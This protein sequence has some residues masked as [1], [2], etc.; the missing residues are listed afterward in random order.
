MTRPWVSPPGACYV[1]PHASGRMRGDTWVYTCPFACSLGIP[2]DS[3]T[4]TCLSACL[5]FMHAGHWVSMH[6]C[7]LRDMMTCH[8][9]GV[10]M[11]G[12]ASCTSTPP[13]YIDT[14]HVKWLIPRPYPLDQATSS[15][16]IRFRDSVHLVNFSPD[17]SRI[18]SAPF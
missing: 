11:H 14:Q 13:Y 7:M 2:E 8:V 1:V 17:Q 10:K 16:S 4:S 6:M 12:T 9:S 5:G 15:F 18:F 3:T